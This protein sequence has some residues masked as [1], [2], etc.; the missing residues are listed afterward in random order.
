VVTSKLVVEGRKKVDGPQ[1]GLGLRGSDELDRD[2][3]AQARH[4][5][6]RAMLA[7]L[8]FAGLRISELLALR[9]R[10]VDLA[11]GWLM[12]S[13]S[14]TDAG[15]RR[16]KIRGALRDDLLAVRASCSAEQEGLVFAS[17]TGRRL[18]AGNFRSRLLAAAT[19]R[20][21]E[22]LAK[23]ARPPLPDGLTPHALRR[24]FASLLYA[25]G[26]SPP[27]VMAEMGHASPALALRVYAQAMRRGEAEKIALQVLVDGPVGQ[28]RTLVGLQGSAS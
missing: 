11:A 19:R 3:Q 25:L 27:V 20:A 22:N 12:V 21:D 28:E 10:D 18:S 9:W 17:R 24:T 13:E 4:I 23:L 2:A 26:E 6:R 1:P 16:V 7:T 8:M 15:R 14:K 5:K